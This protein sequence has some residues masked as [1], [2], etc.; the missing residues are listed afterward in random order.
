[1]LKDHP[2]FVYSST[3]GIL[4]F[5]FHRRW[6]SQPV[7]AMPSTKKVELIIHTASLKSRVQKLEVVDSMK[8]RL[9]SATDV[10]DLRGQ[11]N[12]RLGIKKEDAL[13]LDARDGMK[14]SVSANGKTMYEAA[15]SAAG[16]ASDEDEDDDDEVDHA[17]PGGLPLFGLSAVLKEG[18]RMSE[19]VGSF[20]IVYVSVN[21]QLA[22]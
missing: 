5:L 10:K 19:T 8:T 16:A 12:E 22:A 14:S 3:R 4:Q 13:V 18:K 7:N 11:I 21:A 9:T 20:M 1:M 17:W 2:L 15:V 6:T